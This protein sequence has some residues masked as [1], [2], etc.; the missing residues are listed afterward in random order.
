[1]TRAW[2]DVKLAQAA[3]ELNRP[4]LRS[5]RAGSG[6][7]QAERA[8]DD[9]D[10]RVL[11]PTLSRAGSG[12]CRVV[13]AGAYVELWGPGPKSSCPGRCGPGRYRVVWALTNSESS[14]LGLMSSRLSP[15]R[16][17]IVWTR[18]DVESF[19]HGLMSS[20]A[21][22]SRCQIEWTQVDVESS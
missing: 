17:R 20:W 7:C 21:D 10:S 11:R 13:R 3:V 1:M 19:G 8:W 16:R 9:V 12:R 14:E 18:I 15:G 22:P 2:V 5:S 4:E 6:R